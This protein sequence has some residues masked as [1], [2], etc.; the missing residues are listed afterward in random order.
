MSDQNQKPSDNRTAT[1][2]I[3][4]LENL[5]MSLCSVSDN[6]ARDVMTLKEAI[7]LLDNKVNSIVKAHNAEEALT[8]EVLTRIMMENNSAELAAKVANMVAQGILVPEEVIS[9][10]SFIVGNE[11]DNDGKVHNPRLQFALKAIQAADSREKLQGAK[12]GDLIEF[13]EGALKFKVLE[14]YAIQQPKE[15][16]PVTALAAVSDAPVAEASAE[17]APEAAPAEAP[18]PEASQPAAAESSK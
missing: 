17:V 16:Q 10:N 15:V 4:D 18:A 5:I 14:S 9:E 8:D 7:K 13:K 6:L 1:Q 2:R 11:Q 3:T 12:V